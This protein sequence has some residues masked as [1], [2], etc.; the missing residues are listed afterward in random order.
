[1]TSE[2]PVVVPDARALSRG[3]LWKTCG[4]AAALPQRVSAGL[5]GLG[6]RSLKNHV[7]LCITSERGF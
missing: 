4:N 2:R 6:F 7:P 3:F 1:M 5:D